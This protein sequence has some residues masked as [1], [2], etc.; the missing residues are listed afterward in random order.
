LAPVALRSTCEIDLDLAPSTGVSARKVENFRRTTERIDD[1]GY[2]HEAG[3]L[4]ALQ[5]P[6]VVPRETL[7]IHTRARLL[8]FMHVV[9]R[10]VA[11]TQ[12]VG[13]TD[14]LGT[15]G[16]RDG[17]DRDGIE[18]TTRRHNPLF[19]LRPARRERVQI[20]LAT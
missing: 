3:Q 6:L 9:F 7:D 13:G 10:Y 15:I 4:V 5:C 17:H 14:G 18:I 1:L 11:K 8:E 19:D 16:F 2:R 20:E 12:R